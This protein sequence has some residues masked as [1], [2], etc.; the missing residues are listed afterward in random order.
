M[1][2]LVLIAAGAAA[3]V[4]TLSH[5]V[6]ESLSERTRRRV[7]EL[8]PQLP[9]TERELV[10]R[11]NAMV[12]S[13]LPKVGE[14]LLPSDKEQRSRLAVRLMHAG[15]Y[16]PHAVPVYLLVRLV[17]SSLPALIGLL[18]FFLGVITTRRGL[19]NCVAG[20]LLVFIGSG[21]WL[22]N[23]KAARQL[24]LRHALPDAVDL[25]AI[26]MSGGLSLIAALQ[27]VAD[28]LVTA[29]PPLARELRIVEREM[30]LGST[31]PEGLI[32]FAYRTDLSE[33]RNLAVVVNLA[34][35]YGSSM[36]QTL[37]S[38]SVDLRV[39][40]RQAAE[41][42]ARK[43]AIKVMIPTLLFIFPSIFV[44]ILGPAVVRIYGILNSLTGR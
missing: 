16:G 42:M 6:L 8:S 41:K 33:V 39:K 12:R 10:A 3:C 34:E 38:F 4:A 7:R 11:L 21:H 15:Y 19:M 29:H 40:R 30:Q 20:S 44:V 5:L 23:R 37:E 31:L 32:R 28:E 18:L 43:A 9:P 13:T 35:R 17:I 27:R 26:C 1:I 25:I 36:C 22:D 24:V 14:Q 2:R